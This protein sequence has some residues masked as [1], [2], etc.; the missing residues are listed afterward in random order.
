MRQLVVVPFILFTGKVDEDI[1]RV[2]NGAGR[3]LDLRVLQAHHLELH[4]LLLDV[5]EQRLRE[6]SDGRAAMNCDLCKYRFPMAGYENQV[7]VAQ[8]THHLHD[9][10]AHDHGHAHRENSHEHDDD[11]DIHRHYH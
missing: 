5:A 4:E 6:A 8:I 10:S 7:G 11:R 3:A 2:S 9:G 1:R